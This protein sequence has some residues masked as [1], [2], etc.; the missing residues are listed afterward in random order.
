VIDVQD[1]EPSNIRGQKR[2]VHSVEHQVN[3][4]Y[5]AIAVAVIAV[6]WWVSRTTGSDEEGDGL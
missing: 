2:V 1:P 6:V 4:G 3:W 5:V